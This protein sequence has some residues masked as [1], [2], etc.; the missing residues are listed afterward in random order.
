MKLRTDLIKQLLK[1]E[2]V[3]GSGNLYSTEFIQN[4]KAEKSVLHIDEN[5]EIK[6]KLRLCVD[7]MDICDWFRTKRQEFM[8]SIGVNVRQTQ[9]KNKEHKL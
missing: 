2:R 9:D 4:F 6:G 1:S 3:T 7:N 8:K 5:P